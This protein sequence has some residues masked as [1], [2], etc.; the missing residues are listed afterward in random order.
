VETS[1]VLA[2]AVLAL[3]IAAAN[4]FWPSR[5]RRIE[6]ALAARPRALVHD[7]LGTVRLTGRARRIGELLRAPLSGR[8]CVAYEVVV[9]EPGSARG[10]GAAAWRHRVELHDAQPFL[11]VD[12]TGE[13]RVDTSGPMLISLSYDHTGYTGAFGQFPGD[14]QA[15]ASFLWSLDVVRINWLGRWRR[16]RYAEGVL[17]EGELVSVSADSVLEVDPMGERA[18]LRSP[19]RRLVLRGTE[20]RPL[21]ISDAREVQGSGS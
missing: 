16:F 6:R 7:A 8:P 14:H 13:A 1:P 19:P 5:R 2:L 12:E 4:L 11:V 15:L 10:P 20:A 3:V 21:L 9:D 17:E 18:D